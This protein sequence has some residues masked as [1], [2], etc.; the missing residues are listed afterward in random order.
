MYLFRSVQDFTRDLI[1]WLKQ[2]PYQEFSFALNS[3]HNATWHLKDYEYMFKVERQKVVYPFCANGKNFKVIKSDYN[4]KV[5]PCI[6]QRKQV[7]K[8][9]LFNFAAFIRSSKESRVII[10]GASALQKPK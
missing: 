6:K 7:K 1:N 4:I 9:R 2:V 8:W 3:I 10:D 5:V